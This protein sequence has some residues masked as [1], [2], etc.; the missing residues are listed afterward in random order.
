MRLPRALVPLLILAL[1]HVYIAARLLPALPLGALGKGVGVATAVVSFVMIP[2][3]VFARSFR[4]R[5]TADRVAGLGLFMAGYFSSLLVSTLL[6]DL[7][8][9]VAALFLPPGRFHEVSV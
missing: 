1:L 9:G 2:L 6:R 3:A 7:A 8:L 5:R 4:S